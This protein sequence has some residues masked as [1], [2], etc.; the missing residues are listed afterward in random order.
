MQ[1]FLCIRDSIFT[2]LP[3]A[4]RS[5]LAVPP[6]P[7]T[8][9]RT[10]GR[11]TLWSLLHIFPGEEQGDSLPPGFSSHPRDEGP[12]HCVFTATL[13]VFVLW[14]VISLSEGPPNI[15]LWSQVQE[16]WNVLDGE[17]RCFRQASFRLMLQCWWP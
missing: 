16:G 2:N 17:N 10:A 1:P 7:L 6:W 3:V 11:E 4:P 9:L 14:L 13:L 12:S 15:G 8:G 5:V